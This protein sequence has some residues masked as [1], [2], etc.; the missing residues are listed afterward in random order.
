MSTNEIVDSVVAR[1]RA[2][3]VAGVH[4]LPLADRQLVLL[5]EEAGELVKE[6]RRWRLPSRTP[7]SLDLVAG[8]LADV[9]ITLDV[10]ARLWGCWEV[11]PPVKVEAWV[12]S[13]AAEVAV[14]ASVHVEAGRVWNMRPVG[15]HPPR[16]AQFEHM[17]SQ[18]QWAALVLGVD[19]EAE[20]ARKLAVV[21][22][23]PLWV[24]ER[25]GAA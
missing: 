10:A 1:L 4:E 7:G 23:R 21:A 16:V 15:P 8:E 5:L 17:A 11:P 18:V 12:Q 19:L 24:G 25:R 9:W 22:E 14:V 6:F 2:G 13:R 20:V 3:E